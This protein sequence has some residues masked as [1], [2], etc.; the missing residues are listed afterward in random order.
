MTT[1]LTNTCFYSP[2][3]IGIDQINVFFLAISAHL[4]INVADPAQHHFAG[5]RSTPSP[6]E[7]DLDPTCYY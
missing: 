2:P 7:I 6:E 3:I 1:D 4:T 5:Y